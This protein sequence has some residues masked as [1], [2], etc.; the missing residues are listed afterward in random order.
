MTVIRSLLLLPVSR[1]LLLC[2][3]RYYYEKNLLTKKKHTT[4]LNENTFTQN[5]TTIHRMDRQRWWQTAAAIKTAKK[6]KTVI[7]LTCQISL[8]LPLNYFS[9]SIVFFAAIAAVTD[10]LARRRRRWLPLSSLSFLLRSNLPL[11]WLVVLFDFTITVVIV[12]QRMLP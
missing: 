7:R 6:N 10:V 9:C 11:F 5:G 1:A 4:I 8:H 2:P 3:T 12:Q